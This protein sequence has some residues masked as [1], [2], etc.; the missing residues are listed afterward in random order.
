MFCSPLVVRRKLM[1]M[2]SAAAEAAEK[3]ATAHAMTLA[4]DVS[5]IS[6]SK[7]KA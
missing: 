7:D 5:L 6:L 4:L 1:P 3:S 2:E